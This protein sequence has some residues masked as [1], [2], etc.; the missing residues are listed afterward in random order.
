MESVILFYALAPWGAAPSDAFARLGANVR[1]DDCGAAFKELRRLLTTAEIIPWPLPAATV[2]ELSAHEAF[3]LNLLAMGGPS[4]SKFETVRSRAVAEPV[5]DTAAVATRV[6]ST[7]LLVEDE[8]RAA[9]WWP[10][11]EKR[12]AQHNLRVAARVYSRVSL[13][14][15]GNVVG[16]DAPTLEAQLSELVATK[17]VAAKVDRPAGV[18]SFGARRAATE[19]LSD[20]TSDLDKALGRIEQVCHLIS[21]ETQKALLAAGKQ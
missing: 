7:L 10:I 18:V 14:R 4:A 20:W 16:L 17:Q 12:I 19:V 3:S 11:F 13:S 6:G 21:K 2:A 8:P 5:V 9:R 15:L 1:L